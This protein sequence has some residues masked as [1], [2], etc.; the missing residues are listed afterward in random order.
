MQLVQQL[1]AA[2]AEALRRALAAR[3]FALPDVHERPSAVSVPGA[4][5]LWLTPE[6]AKGPREAFLVGTEFAHLHPAPDWSL[7]MAL[8]PALADEAVQRGWAEAHPMARR[9][10]I[11][12]SVVMVYAPR[13]GAEVEVVVGLVGAAHAFAHGDAR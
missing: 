10:L 5:A 9:G 3:V 12:P 7:H 4:R 2:E 6:S 13:D 11:P 1:P 8:P